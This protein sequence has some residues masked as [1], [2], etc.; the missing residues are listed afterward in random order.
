MKLSQDVDAQKVLAEHAKALKPTNNT[1]ASAAVGD[2]TKSPS[3][4]CLP[5][6]DINAARARRHQEL[7]KKA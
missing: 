3:G 5:P 2:W 4:S 7:K 1:V 6:F